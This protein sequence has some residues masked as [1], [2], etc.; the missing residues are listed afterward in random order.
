MG[1]SFS[2]PAELGRT[3]AD[4]ERRGSAIQCQLFRTTKASKGQKIVEEEIILGQKQI[5][6]LAAYTEV[7]SLSKKTV[8][9]DLRRPAKN[10]SGSGNMRLSTVFLSGSELW[11]GAPL[12]KGRSVGGGDRSSPGTP[13]RFRAFGRRSPALRPQ[14]TRAST[15][16][17][18][19]CLVSRKKRCPEKA[20]E[21]AWTRLC[22]LRSVRNSVNSNT[23]SKIK[24]GRTFPHPPQLVSGRFFHGR[25]KGRTSA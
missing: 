16:L 24:S 10:S 21:H 20:R 22:K 9:S 25:E 2:Q 15:V 13:S 3:F 8:M 11:G 6:S 23:K 12:Q 18:N 14:D 17:S 1:S 7:N 4:S 5:K 19:A